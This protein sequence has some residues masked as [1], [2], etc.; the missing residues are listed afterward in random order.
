MSCTNE[1]VVIPRSREQDNAL[2]GA[3][4]SALHPVRRRWISAGVIGAG[5]NGVISVAQSA[6]FPAEFPLAQLLP[7]NGGDGTNG[8]VLKGIGGGNAGFSVSGAG[9]VNGDG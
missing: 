3:V 8:F 5:L 7:A 9:D 1:S 2:P 6:P 4:R